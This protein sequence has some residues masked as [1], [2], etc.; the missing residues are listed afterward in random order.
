[1]FLA[2]NLKHNGINFLLFVIILLIFGCA[3]TLPPGITGGGNVEFDETRYNS[4]DPLR[5]GRLYDKWWEERSIQKPSGANPIWMEIVKFVPT[6]TNG[7]ENQWR[8]KEC[9]G[10][11]YKGATGAYGPN[12]SHYTG[13]RGLNN[14]NEEFT[15]EHVFDMIINGEVPYRPDGATVIASKLRHRYASDNISDNLMS[16]NDAYDLTSFVMLK[17]NQDAGNPTAGDSASGAAVFESVGWGCG[18]SGCHTPT[19]TLTPNLADIIDVAQTNPQEF[20]H[21]VRYGSPGSLMPDGLDRISAQ[22]VRAY[23][24]AGAPTNEV[25]NSNFIQA[26]YDA[27]GPIDVV[28]GGKLYDKYWEVA[29]ATEPPST[30]PRWP[31]TNT[32]ISGS[33][34]WRCKECHGWDYRGADGAYATGKHATGIQGIVTTTGFIMQNSGAAGVYGFLKTNVE[35][36]FTMTFTEDEFYQLTKF[37]MTMRTEVAASQSGVNFIDDAT[38]L[39]KGTDA[40]NGKVLYDTA[41]T[42]SCSNAGCHGEDGKAFDFA[43]GDLDNPPNEFVHH[44]A[45]ENPWEFIHKIRFGQPNYPA[46]PTLYNSASATEN[47]I[48]AAADILAYSQT[49]LV[50]SI[51]RAG[52]LY[53]KWWDVEG[54]KDA[55]VPA[56]RN[57]TWVSNAGT[58]DT[59]KVSDNSTWRCKECHGWDYQGVHGAYG[60]DGDTTGKHYSGIRG[61][62]GPLKSADKAD[63]VLIE[64]IKTGNA[65]ELLTDHDF[66][67]FLSDSDIQLLVDFIKDT[68]LGVPASVEVYNNLLTTG[69]ATQ[70]KIVYDEESPGNCLACHG[71]KGTTI[72][73]V[74]VGAIANDNPQEFLH[75]VRYGHPGSAMLPTSTGFTGLTQEFASNVLAYAK[76][77]SAG[78]GPDPDPN[79]TYSYDTADPVRGGRLYDKWWK[80][81][82]A[83]DETVQNPITMNP[84]WATKDATVPDFPDTW[85]ANKQI[86]SSW[87]CKTCHAWNYKGVGFSAGDPDNLINKIALRQVTFPDA[88]DLQNYLYNWIKNGLGNA[89]HKFG[90]VLPAIPSPMGEREL[91]DLVRFLLDGGV[92]DSSSNIVAGI[93]I[94]VDTNNGQGLYTG[95]VEPTVNC[96]DCHGADGKTSPPIDQGGS[97]DALDIF[98][99]AASGSN[100]WEYLHKVR[101]GQPGTSMPAIFRTGSLTDQ[102]AFDLLGYGQQQFNAR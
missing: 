25:P 45:Q 18:N 26:T 85:T 66:G 95:S 83:T 98:D 34:T 11:D 76:T 72:A 19:A 46:M 27:L 89:D 52:L 16:I 39:T 93:A 14:A 30:H 8:C 28:K 101:F 96:V 67:R 21:K 80:E 64:A 43:D 20:L 75:K 12:S 51:K 1:M 15:S 87:R 42:A 71:D 102:D 41:N 49:N 58:A 35:H 50:P 88:I 9:H 38:K 81:M 62:L 10:W 73:T 29:V 65:R 59:A 60:Y 57:A 4:A 24:A 32:A 48:Q 17:A 70:G 94:G 55:T 13:V 2:K 78:G 54:I 99:I 37:I 68:A 91:W 7:N 63:S 92:I 82:Q 33:G 53:D 86:E 90:E 61:Y 36:G 79:P 5:G 77:L 23:V 56:N 44:I 74:D 22:D 100:P 40:A 84:L 47:T 6:N 97:G 69:N 3:E 31:T